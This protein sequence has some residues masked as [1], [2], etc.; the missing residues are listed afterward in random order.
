VWPLHVPRV[1]SCVSGARARAQVTEAQL[2]QIFM[3]FGHVLE[4]KIYRKGSYGFV[5]FQKHEDAVRAIV[6]MNG[7]LVSGRALKCSWGRHQ[8]RALPRAGQGL[9]EH[10][11]ALGMGLKAEEAL[12]HRTACVCAKPVP[13][14]CVYK[15]QVLGGLS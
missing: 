14:M 10:A 15:V 8:V 9:G 7:G 5:Q 2:Q 11:H 1:A 13:P 12:M 3:Q 6:N 4:V